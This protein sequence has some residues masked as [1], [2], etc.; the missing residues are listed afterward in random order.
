MSSLVKTILKRF[1]ATSLHTTI[2]HHPFVRVPVNHL[3]KFTV[4]RKIKRQT[5]E[6]RSEAEL[7]ICL[8]R[9]KSI[10]IHYNLEAES[11]NLGELT[12]C[13]L[14]AKYLANFGH[15]VH[16]IL[17]EPSVGRQVSENRFGHGRLLEMRSLGE[18]I[19]EG[20]LEFIGVNS[21]IYCEG[22]EENSSHI[23]FEHAYSTQQAI[24]THVSIL[25]GLS[26]MRSK[27]GTPTNLVKWNPSG[28]V[29]WH[30]RNSSI[31][32]LRN[33]RSNNQLV[34][35][36]KALTR[37]FPTKQIRIFTDDSGRDRVEI[38][39]QKKP[40]LR[41]LF[42]SGKITFQE[43]KSYSTAA[44]EAAGCDF[45]F[46]RLGGGIGVIPLF[47][48]MPFLILSEDFH[49]FRLA[50]GSGSLFYSW[51]GSRQIWHLSA[52]ASF[53]SASK[54]LAKFKTFVLSV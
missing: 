14:F 40:E 50:G 11:P 41:T 39:C 48:A 16:F 49:S 17:I 30:V 24:F 32:K 51:H 7:L 54:L 21:N 44:I 1:R 3:Q 23:L 26:E 27:F 5:L 45:W 34:A 42:D 18:E 46:Q 52:Y 35:D 53:I 4:H 37:V 19:A 36:A 12:T 43:A 28:Y 13:L 15:K 9:E 25:F 38:A 31:D 22:K 8:P 47:S 6:A 29:G 33:Y 2:T 10:K 20:N